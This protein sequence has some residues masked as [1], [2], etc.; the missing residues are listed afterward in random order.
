MMYTAMAIWLLSG[1]V[2]GAMAAGRDRDG[3]VWMLIGI[4]FGP[5]AVLALLLFGKPEA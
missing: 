2:A 3:A 1:L 5:L 4:L